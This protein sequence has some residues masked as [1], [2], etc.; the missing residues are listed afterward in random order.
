MISA[1]VAAS[2]RRLPS[3]RAID[4]MRVALAVIGSSSISISRV[5]AFAVILVAM[6]CSAV[7]STGMSIRFNATCT[8][9]RTSGSGSVKVREVRLF[10]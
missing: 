10:E 6:P 7:P 8:A 5:P 3:R 9:C 2:S 1:P 4:C